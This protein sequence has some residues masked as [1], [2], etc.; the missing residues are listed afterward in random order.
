M[1]Q[2]FFFLFM[3]FVT[4]YLKVNLVKRNILIAIMVMFYFSL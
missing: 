3:Y 2:F 1:R 4:V